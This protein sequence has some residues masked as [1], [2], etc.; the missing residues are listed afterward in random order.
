MPLFEYRQDAREKG[1]SG[2]KVGAIFTLVGV[3]F[4]LPAFLIVRDTESLMSLLLPQ[5]ALFGLLGS[6]SLLLGLG[7][8]ILSILRIRSGGSWQ[9]RV[10]PHALMWLEPQHANWSFKVDIA[11][12]SSI[13]QRRYLKK[14]RSGRIK[15]HTQYALALKAGGEHPLV[16]QFGMDMTQF[17]DAL[18]KA[19]VA[20]RD[21]EVR[22]NG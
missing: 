20:V 16:N 21:E 15:S 5:I 4:L 7:M 9:V 17:I 10:T 19:G 14:K 13:I 1:W 2:L 3:A 18:R 11:D 8:A 22:V 6:L 12:L